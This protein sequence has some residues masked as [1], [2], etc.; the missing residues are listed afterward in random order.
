VSL[1]NHPTKVT[2][3]MVGNLIFSPAETVVS[4]AIANK[5]AA[6]IAKDTVVL[7]IFI[8]IYSCLTNN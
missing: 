6:T 2:K 7:L 4:T 1:K 5:P 3:I 8:I